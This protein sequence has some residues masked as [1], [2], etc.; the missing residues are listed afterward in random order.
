MKDLEDT[1]CALST[2]PGRSGIAVVRMSGSQSHSI[3]RRIFRRN[4]LPEPPP[5]RH[6]MLGTIV[7]PRDGYEID[8]ALVLHF[9]APNSY[10][11]QD[12]VEISI[13]GSPVLAAALLDCLCAM[14]ARPA[15]PGEFT[16][17]AFLSGRIDLTQAEA[18]RDIIDATTLYQAQIAG[19][20]RSGQLAKRLSPIKELLVDV[21]VSLES[22]V[23]FVEEDL[24]V[25]SRTSVVFKIERIQKQLQNWVESYRQGRII[26]E[27]FS[28][29]VVGR[30]N[31]G[32]SSIFNALLAQDRSIV[33][34]LP[35]TTR[36]L[37]S[38]ITSIGGIPFRLQDT[39]GINQSED[40]IERMGVERSLQAI[41]EADAV[42]LV[43]DRSRPYSEKDRDLKRQLE[44]LACISVLN[45]SDLPSV[46]SIDEKEDFG[47]DLPRAEVSAL[48]GAGIEQ[49][50][51]A[52]LERILGAD[53]VQLDG[54]LITNLRHCRYLEEAN[55][56]LNQA[57]AAL[58]AGL[59]E[60]FA[61][62]DLHKGL[63]I[64]GAITGEIH[65]ENLLDEIFSR[66]CIGK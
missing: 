23:E 26:K 62:V 44:N 61:L 45:K 2:V 40:S 10:T 29:A 19:R 51:K 11:R 60:E 42:L 21:I 50:R 8:E 5:P 32:K 18:V 22:A 59:S 65:V 66:F 9:H 41:A 52:I 24:P 48:T 3:C 57:A 6:A 39:A 43:A 30:P 27:G 17:R 13:H 35:G 31:V 25:E 49:L 58:T 53:A 63:K 55:Q 15:E 54:I 33:T 64:L 38:E 37:V 46:W 14:G 12:M 20:Q 1:I 56:N 47:G 28:L 4:V 16:M 36:D 34:D 7:D